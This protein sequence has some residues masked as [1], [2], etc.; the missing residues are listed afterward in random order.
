L[1][2]YR[3][4]SGAFALERFHLLEGQ[5][6]VALELSTEELLAILS[7]AIEYFRGTDEDISAARIGTLLAVARNPGLQQ[8][9]VA[10]HVCGLST[11]GISRNVMDWSELDTKRRPGPEYISQRPDP[12]YRRRNLLFL[13]PKGHQYL[14]R[15]TQKVNKDAKLRAK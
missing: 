1:D 11:S 10:D 8:V 5:L 7:S 4:R 14:E 6:I 15:L 9:D 13:T 3:H 12:E 2:C